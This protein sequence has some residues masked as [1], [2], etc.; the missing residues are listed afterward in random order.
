MTRK[1]K[2]NLDL[3]KLFD[4]VVFSDAPKDLEVEIEIEMEDSPESYKKLCTSEFIKTWNFVNEEIDEDFSVNNYTSV[5]KTLREYNINM[6]DLRDII[7][8]SYSYFCVSQLNSPETPK[9]KDVINYFLV[10]KDSIKD[11]VYSEE[12][13]TSTLNVLSGG[14]PLVEYLE[15]LEDTKKGNYATFEEFYKKLF[16]YGTRE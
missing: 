12:F 14:L 2:V 4:G 6:K 11:K 5:S 10:N 3:S 13:I 15:K 9:I 1:V 7:M 16:Q 8:I